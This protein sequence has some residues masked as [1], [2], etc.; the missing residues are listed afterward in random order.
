[1]VIVSKKIFDKLT[2]GVAIICIQKN[3]GSPNPLGGRA[4]RDKARLVLNLENEFPGHYVKITKAK[5]WRT[6]ENPN[7]LYKY[8]RLHDGC[9]FS[10]DEEWRREYE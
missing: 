8:Y 3:P 10:P 2:T 5:N 4:A 7:G 1:M 6:P 9:Q